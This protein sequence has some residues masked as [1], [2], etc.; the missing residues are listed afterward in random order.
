MKLKIDLALNSLNTFLN[1][2]F[3]LLT[4]PLATRALGPQMLGV[5]NFSVALMVPLS[6]FAAL[7]VTG[8]AV[9]QIAQRD[10]SRSAA[11]TFFWE[12]IALQMTAV[13]PAWT[14]FEILVWFY[15]GWSGNF[16]LFQVA[17][18][19]ILIGSL[20]SEW[21]F[22]GRQRFFFMALRNFSVKLIV[23]AVV[24]VFVHTP[25]DALAY[26]VAI[27]LGLSGSQIINFVYAA[28]EVGICD[29]K[30][31]PFRHLRELKLFAPLQVA[32]T[33]QM[34][35]DKV[36][37]GYLL[38]SGSLAFYSLADRLCSIAVSLSGAVTGVMLPRQS[39]AVA[40]SGATAVWRDA[41]TALWILL[42]IAVLL[43]VGMGLTGHAWSIVLFGKAFGPV[44]EILNILRWNLILY[45]LTLFIGN[46]ILLPSG[47]QSA[48]LKTILLGT[49]TQIT[50]VPVTT[51][52]MGASGTAYGMI[53]S[54]SVILGAMFWAC[55]TDIIPVLRSFLRDRDTWRRVG[56]GVV[57]TLGFDA[58]PRIQTVSLAQ[59]AAFTLAIIVCYVLTLAVSGDSW[60]WGRFRPSQ[61]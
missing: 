54:N 58:L 60:I 36:V 40:G 25:K 18:A 37:G 45:I 34:S 21:Y 44:G 6:A 26:M 29:E 28:W 11:A 52:L 9:I 47:R 57:V 4:L 14:L 1:I 3:P 33:L 20:S 13:V 27:S 41:I 16:I 8:Y 55:R 49:V 61:N 46:M 7:G 43:V 2:C 32:T 17:G 35:F 39:R 59:T 53:A 30:L 42:P 24:M 15:G 31:R 56:A 51:W 12:M 19:N 23:L 22:V 10:E 38:S 50:V 5:V 48:Y